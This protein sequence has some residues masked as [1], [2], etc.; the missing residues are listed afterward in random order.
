MIFKH[1][2]ALIF[3]VVDAGFSGKVLEASRKAGAEGATILNGR[4]RGV[5][6]SSTFMGV[7]IQPDKEIILILVKKSIRRNVMK[8]IVRSSNLTTEGKG[9]TFCVPVDEVAGVQHLLTHKQRQD[10]I[11]EQKCDDKVLAKPE[12]KTEAKP[13]AK[14]E[15]QLE[16]NL[17]PKVADNIAVKTD[18]K[19][20]AKLE[21]QNDA[22]KEVKVEQSVAEKKTEIKA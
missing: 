17:Q 20:G 6:E 3:T 13:E 7:S 15:G 11:N 18:S 22:K 10:D 9:M 5:H 19:D 2:F 1:G 21:V 4:G 16:M 8:E 14:N 12:N